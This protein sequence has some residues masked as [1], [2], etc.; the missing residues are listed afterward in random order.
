MRAVHWILLLLN[1]V[2]LAQVTTQLAANIMAEKDMKT[3]KISLNFECLAAP[4]LPG[5]GH[6]LQCS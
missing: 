1:N 6:S 4:H 3:Y 5:C 2:I